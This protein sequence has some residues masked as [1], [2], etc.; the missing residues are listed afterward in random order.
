[1][2]SV[3]WADQPKNTLRSSAASCPNQHSAVYRSVYQHQTLISAAILKSDPISLGPIKR[4]RA[5]WLNRRTRSKAFLGYFHRLNTNMRTHAQLCHVV[6][7]M[8]G[9]RTPAGQV[10]ICMCVCTPCLQILGNMSSYKM[11]VREHTV[12][13]TRVRPGASREMDAWL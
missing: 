3:K 10:S 4:S 8:L 12:R 11:Q 7:K 1:V 9:S 13:H 2:Q 5:V 6:I